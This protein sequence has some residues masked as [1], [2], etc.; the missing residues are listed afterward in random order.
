[1]EATIYRI[2]LN[3]NGGLA[4]TPTPRGGDWLEVEVQRLRQAG[5]DVLVSALMDDEQSELGLETEAQTCTSQGIEFVNL[6][7]PDLGTP[8]DSPNFLSR[9]AELAAA[10]RNGRSVAVHCRQSVGRSGLIAT[11]IMIALGNEMEAAI[12]IMSKARGV[13]VPETQEQRNWLAT[14]SPALS[15]LPS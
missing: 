2:P 3:T 9:I 14:H 6:P 4:I 11:A 1:M 12:Q 7:M 5:V 10:L 15:K 13:S 8:L